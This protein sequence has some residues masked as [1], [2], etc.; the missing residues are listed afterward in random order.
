MIPTPS[1]SRKFLQKRKFLL[2][3]PVLAIPFLFLLFYSLGG[4]GSKVPVPTNAPMG[5]N[6]ELPKAQFQ[7]QKTEPNKLEVYTKADADSLKRKEYFQQDPYHKKIFD[8]TR[9]LPDSP[10]HQPIEAYRGAQDPK[11][12][13]LLKRLDQLRQS[14]Q[15][16]PPP[17]S[18]T[19]HPDRTA[20]P[21]ISRLQQVLRSIRSTDTVS[22]EDPQLQKLNIMLDKIIHI[23]HPGETEERLGALGATH[24][25]D[26]LPADTT[27]N[28]IPATI[29]EDQT[30]VAGATIAL[31]LTETAKIGG[32]SLPNNQLVYGIVSINND[33][34]LI[35]IQS[36]RHQHSIYPADL[37]VYDMDG[38]PGIHIPGTLNRE[39]AKQSADQG[40]NT[41]N[42]ATFD[43][44]I[45]AQAA[46]AGLQAAKTLFSRKVKLVRIAVRAGYQVLLYNAKA[47]SKLANLRLSEL[48]SDTSPRISPPLPAFMHQQV[49]TEKL[50]LTLR[51]IYLQQNIL[52]FSLLLYNDGPIDY[53]PEYIRWTIRDRHQV[54]RTALQD[55]PLSPVYTPPT[56]ILPGYSNRSLVIGFQPFA[57]ARDKELVLQMGER[58]GARVL[59]MIIDHKAI[60]KAKTR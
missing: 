3:L 35:H 56:P 11:A 44:S 38:L 29:S 28:A 6:P 53:L 12:D 51:G 22:D 54:R 42:L 59:T 32:V 37:Q 1:Y 2:V 50:T 33:R 49:S 39:V 55:L 46:N 40:I 20:A 25:N 5:F 47:G 48:H 26:W 24:N 14:I 31:R 41:V 58:N 8:S 36:I 18:T 27:A 43:P 10:F 30:L 15:Q 17:V 52:W 9:H 23:Q 45:G 4:G 21:D 57:L 34:M 60:L 7:R 16:P 19:H 13:E